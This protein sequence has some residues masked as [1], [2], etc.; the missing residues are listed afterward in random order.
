MREEILALDDN[1]T[2]ELTELPSNRKPIKNKWVFKTKR[3][4]DGEIERYKARLVVKGCSQRPGID[5]DE[6]YSPVVRYS[7]IRYLLGMAVKHDLD[8]E[9]MDA[10]TAFLQG[11][12]TDEVIFMD[13]PEGF[14]GD[15]R[16]VCRLG[17]LFMD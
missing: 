12:L 5:F 8:V 1:H 14:V 13:Q 9:Q 16:K 6:V 7:T 2:W 17:K 11:N 10:V 15:R 3:G 4:A